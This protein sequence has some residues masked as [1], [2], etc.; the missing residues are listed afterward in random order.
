M[1]AQALTIEKLPVDAFAGAAK[2]NARLVGRKEAAQ[3]ETS[4]RMVQVG[5]F[6][7][8]E[9]ALQKIRLRLLPVRSRHLDH[10]T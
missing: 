9:V 4:C 5:V 6:A 3:L 2:L 7:V 8:A 10:L 1:Q